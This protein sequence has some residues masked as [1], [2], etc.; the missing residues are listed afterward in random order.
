MALVS[1]RLSRTPIQKQQEFFSDFLT[2]FDVS[3]TKNDLLR[4]TNEEAVKTSIRN[5]LLTNRGDRLFNNT[6]GSDLRALLFENASPALE[7]LVG[8]YI[9][10]TI[11]NYEPRAI[12]DQVAVNTELDQN[13]VGVTIVFRVINKQ[14]P[15]VFDLTLNR[16]R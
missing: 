2:N 8:D 14:E 15:V 4:V 12:V 11:K 9:Q 7:Q 1:T 6:V 16:I 5:L 13:L 10:T 3:D